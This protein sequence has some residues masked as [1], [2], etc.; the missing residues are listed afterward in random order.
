MPGGFPKGLAFMLGV[1]PRWIY[2]DSS[3]SPL[4]ALRFEEPLAELKSRLASG[5]QVFEDLLKA[6]RTEWSSAL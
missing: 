6:C 4:D 2:R 5:E 1:L 3:S